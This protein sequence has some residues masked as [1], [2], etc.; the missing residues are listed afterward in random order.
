MKN[1]CIHTVTSNAGNSFCKLYNDRLNR[2]CF[3]LLKPCDGTAA[4]KKICPEWGLVALAEEQQKKQ[5]REA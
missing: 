1:G 3:Q 5:K 4:E 2:S